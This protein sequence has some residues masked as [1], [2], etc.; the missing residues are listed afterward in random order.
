MYTSVHVC[1]A[2]AAETKRHLKS[3]KKKKKKKNKTHPSKEKKKKKKRV[4]RKKMDFPLEKYPQVIVSI[5]SQ[6][7]GFPKFC[8]L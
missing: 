5:N 1:R 3:Q 6:Y 8:P 4:Q 2:G 7:V